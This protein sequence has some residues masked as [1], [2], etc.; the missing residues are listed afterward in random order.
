[1]LEPGRLFDDYLRFS[2]LRS[3]A[4]VTK[5][6]DLSMVGWFYPTLLLPLGI[7]KI[8]NQDIE[9]ILPRDPNVSNYFNIIT[10]SSET[11]GNKSYIPIIKISKDKSETYEMLKKLNIYGIDCGGLNPLKY[12]TNELVDNI[13]QHS[14]FST[15]YIM[16]Q[17]YQNFLEFC[18]IDNGISIP[19]SY[20]NIGLSMEN[21]KA[22][23]DRA[24]EGLS[25]KEGD[26]RGHGLRSSIRLL[27]EG[28]NGA[29]LIVSRKGGLRVNRE[30]RV[31]FSIDEENIYDGT[32]IS[33]DVPFQ[34]K[35]VDLYEYLY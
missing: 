4:F 7:F 29:C 34:E 26:G 6:L 11:I 30:K 32:L 27:T 13:Y 2:Q 9:V 33:I 3:D 22:A 24:L 25:A 28:M 18:I 15:A 31:S 1:V 35:P 5:K 17:K 8:Q 19:Q 16:A 12:F 20:E 14:K 23:L 21:D 10:E